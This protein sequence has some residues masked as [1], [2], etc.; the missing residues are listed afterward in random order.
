MA[1]LGKPPPL[2]ATLERQTVV[3]F[4]YIYSCRLHARVW[5]Q[6]QILQIWPWCES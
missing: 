3:A 1:E 5:S 6:Q 2:E 4:F